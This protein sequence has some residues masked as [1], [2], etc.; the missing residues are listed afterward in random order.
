MIIM[1]EGRG[2]M[3]V[4]RGAGRR[5]VTEWHGGDVTGFLPFSRMGPPVGDPL[6]DDAS[7]GL[8]VHRNQFSRD[9]P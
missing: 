3:Y 5:K 6:I 2:G 1:L 8:V 7:V 4:D 9:D